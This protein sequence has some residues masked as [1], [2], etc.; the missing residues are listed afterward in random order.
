VYTEEQKHSNDLSQPIVALAVDDMRSATR[1]K[2]V[3]FYK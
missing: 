1:A 2:G 3:D